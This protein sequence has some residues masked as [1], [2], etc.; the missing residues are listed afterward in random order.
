MKGELWK[1]LCPKDQTNTVD[2]KGVPNRVISI[3]KILPLN[4][5]RVIDLG[6]KD[7]YNSFELA[8]YGAEEVVGIEI[9]DRYL[10]RANIIKQENNYDKVSFVKYDVRFIDQAKLGKFD[11]CLC[12]GLLYHMVNPFNLLKRIR[13]ICNVLMLETHI[14]PSSILNILRTNKFYRQ[15]L[16]IRKYE[17][18][19]DGEI[20]SG[21]F[22]YLPRNIDREITSGSYFFNRTFWL[23]KRSLLKA[24]SL[25][26]FDIKAVYFNR[27]PKGYPNIKIR[28]GFSKSKIFIYAVVIEPKKIIPVQRSKIFCENKKIDLEIPSSFRGEITKAISMIKRRLLERIKSFNIC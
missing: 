19:L 12:S 25:A 14:A 21:R 16:T 5:L 7:G 6:C 1:M 3:Q 23:D 9:R 15:R 28:H 18:I 4:G 13:N 20:F 22:K 17:V 2:I 27:T 24:L 8:D 11:I 26:G 10:N